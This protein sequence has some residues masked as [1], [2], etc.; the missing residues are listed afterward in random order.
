MQSS[1]I[2]VRQAKEADFQKIIESNGGIGSNPF[3]QFSSIDRIRQLPPLG[4]L[5]AEINKVY[6]GFLYWFLIDEPKK[7]VLEKNA[8]IAIVNVKKKYT[9]TKVGLKLLQKALTDIDKLQVTAISVNASEKNTI[10]RDLYEEIGFSTVD[11]TLHMRYL[12]T[13]R[14]NLERRSDEENRELAVFLVEL[15]EQCRTFRTTYSEIMEMISQGPPVDED[16]KRI[17]SVKIWSRIQSCLASCSIISKILWKSQISRKG[18]IRS[19][20]LRQILELPEKNPFP[21]QVRNSFEHIDERLSDWLPTQSD[22]IPWGWC[23]SA[24][25]KEEEPRD[26]RQ[27]FRYF[28][29]DTLELRVAGRS[30]NLREVME[31]VHY[32]EERIPTEAQIMFRDNK[33]V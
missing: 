23:L 20:E 31:Q 6:A 18:L 16:E 24:F 26:S 29:I 2:V 4:L 3:N 27:A 9:K 7:G 21:N 1:D 22:D 33:S 14:D 19:R 11:R 32:I 5:V 8:H 30:C 13:P 15:S 12:Y 10:L 28:Q 17:F 25:N